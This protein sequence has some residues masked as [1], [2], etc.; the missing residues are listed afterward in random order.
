MKLLSPKPTIEASVEPASS[1]RAL[2]SPTSRRNTAPSEGTSSLASASWR[3]R[4]GS[5]MSAQ[6]QHARAAG[7]GASR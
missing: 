2:L 1:W 5:A 6:A 4:G 7:P 3:P